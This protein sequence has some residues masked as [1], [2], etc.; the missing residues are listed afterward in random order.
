MASAKPA[1]VLGVLLVSAIVCTRNR[2]VP[3]AT[4]VASLLSL[5]EEA[6]ELIVVDQSDNSE[7]ERALAT[8]A[9]DP[10]FRYVRSGGRGKG[11]AL[12][13]G[14]R[15]AQGT[16]IVCTDDDCQPPPG[17][18]TAMANA[19][20]SQPTA[21]VLFCS[22]VPVP[23]DE[24][25]GYVPAYRL[26]KN[27]LLRSVSAICSGLGIG[28]GMALRRDFAVAM[29]GFDE[30]FGPGARFPSADEWDISM[31]A[32]LSGGHVYETSDISIVH[33]GFRTFEEGRQH[34]QRDWIALGA[35]CAKPISA[36]HYRAV[37]VPVWLFSVRALLPPV[38]DLM[39]LRKP[40]GAQRILAFIRGFRVGLGLTV[41]PVTLRFSD[42][43]KT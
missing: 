17:W 19:L 2:A 28:A 40:R 25:S 39:R 18:A 7:T 37:V 13:E 8:F 23:H 35:A 32:L 22:V 6:L 41:D 11:A 1:T 14:I 27:R 43:P 42:P 29:G 20:L 9:S 24:N 16:V 5:N 26:K 12:N 4:V 21:V 15:L 3:V 33:D 34:A 36:G 31:R 10:R 30:S 38:M